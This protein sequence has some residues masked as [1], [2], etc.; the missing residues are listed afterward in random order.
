MKYLK[1]QEEID[2]GEGIQLIP[3]EKVFNEKNGKNKIYLK[4]ADH[5]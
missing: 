5:L 4:I 2:S 3:R 1:K